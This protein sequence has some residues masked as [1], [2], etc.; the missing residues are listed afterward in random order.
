MGRLTDG[1]VELQYLFYPLHPLHNVIIC[2][3]AL[4]LVNVLHDNIC[5]A[6]KAK[7][8]K[9][10]TN[11]FPASPRHQAPIERFTNVQRE[12]ETYF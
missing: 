8:G 7:C 9:K 11:N 12:A 4:P 10:H 3:V 5:I 6:L 2:P 1:R